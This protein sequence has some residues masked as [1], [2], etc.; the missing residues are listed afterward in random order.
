MPIL[1]YSTKISVDRSVTEI[2]KILSAHGA[3]AIMVENDETGT[4]RALS[5]KIAMDGQDVGYRLPA[6]WKPLLQI[7]ERDNRV[8]R[9][10][11]TEE[12]AKCVTWRILKDWVEAQMAILETR[13][14]KMDQIFLPYAITK[15]GRTLYETVKASN[16]LSSPL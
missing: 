15:D 5:F 2:M 14:V 12:H 4:I 8:P 7:I 6:D 10:K 3:N 9:A 16:L 1:N 13:M 11:K